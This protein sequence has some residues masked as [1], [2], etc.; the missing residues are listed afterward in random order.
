MR[1]SDWSSDVCSSDLAGV[2]APDAPAL[3]QGDRLVEILGEGVLGLLPQLPTVAQEQDPSDPF[4]AHQQFGERNGHARLSCTRRLHNKRFASPPVEL[5][6]D[7][8]DRLDLIEPPGDPRV[9][10]KRSDEHTSELQSLI[11]LSYAA[12]C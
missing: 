8:L 6:R 5:L 4:R 9:R 1:I 11:R 12:F 2:V 10:S 3:D 7:P